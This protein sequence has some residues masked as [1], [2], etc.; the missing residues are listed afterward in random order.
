MKAQNCSRIIQNSFLSR[1]VATVNNQSQIQ[2]ES[3]ILQTEDKQNP[4]TG[5]DIPQF[6]PPV[7]L[8][9]KTNERAK[10]VILLGKILTEANNPRSS[11]NNNN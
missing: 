4:F 2:S 10:P 3:P 7:V 9:K 6:L 5:N 1:D 11:K 8:K